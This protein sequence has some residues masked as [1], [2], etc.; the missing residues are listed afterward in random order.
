MVAPSAT[1][2]L[3]M[4][5]PFCFYYVRAVRSRLRLV[6]GLCVFTAIVS[7]NTDRSGVIFGPGSK[8]SGSGADFSYCK[9]RALCSALLFLLFSTLVGKPV[10]LGSDSVGFKD[11]IARGVLLWLPVSDHNFLQSVR[12]FRFMSDCTINTVRAFLAYSWS[13]EATCI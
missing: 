7:T 8:S 9:L 3:L 6:T 1:G 13:L 2:N 12:Y 10:S 11:I 4:S 5:T